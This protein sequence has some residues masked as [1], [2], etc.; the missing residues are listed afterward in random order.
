MKSEAILS[1]NV[2]CRSCVPGTLTSPLRLRLLRSSGLLEGHPRLDRLT[3]LAAKLLEVPTV[4][5][6]LVDIDRQVFASQVGLQSPHR[7]NAQTPLS[8]SFCQHVVTGGQPLIVADAR[9]DALLC[10]NEAI[11][12]LQVIAYA[13]FPIVCREQVMGSFCAIRPTPHDWCDLELELLSQ[14]AEAVSDQVEVRTDYEELK[15]ASE[16][17]REAN[18]GLENMAEVLAHDLTTPLRGIRGC[19]HIFEEMVGELPEDAKEMLDEVNSSATRMSEL[20]AAL[21]QFGNALHS[22]AEMEKL[23]MNVLFESVRK[24]LKEELSSTEALVERETDLGETI[25]VQPLLR[26]LL[27]NLISNAIKFQSEG[28]KPQI[29]VGRR[30]NDGAFYVRDNGVGIEE[31]AL[32]R[33]F[34]IYRK[35][36]DG[37]K[38]SGMGLGLTICARIVSRHNG[39][40]WVESKPGEGSTFYFILRSRLY[41][42]MEG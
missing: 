26:Q 4:L 17:L 15:L 5:V 13:G 42:E 3:G 11:R 34:E 20:I 6:S 14:F 12:D 19:L 35:G 32:E 39:R 25:G 33:I 1:D 28:R 37:K 23:D 21:S 10:T 8:H 41:Q 40:I 38:F 29:Q 7:E 36:H 2:S 22:S 16:N 27:Q 18:E 30:L 9:K 24:D 31:K